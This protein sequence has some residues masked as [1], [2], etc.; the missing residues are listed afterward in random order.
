[1]SQ[2][3]DGIQRLETALLYWLIRQAARKA[4]DD[5]AD[6]LEEEWCADLEDRD[7]SLSRACFAL[8]CCWAVAVIVQDIR[9][10]EPVPVVGTG[11]TAVGERPLRYLTLRS[12]T[13][14]LILGLHAAL[15]WGLTT[16]L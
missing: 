15:F 10:S 6:R 8:G 12:P 14:F 4:P 16:L 3:N 5:L 7:S 1:M 2:R 9:R 11:A 13:M